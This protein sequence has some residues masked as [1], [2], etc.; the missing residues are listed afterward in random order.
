MGRKKRPHYRIV[1]MEVTAP[2]NGRALAEVGLYDP[3]KATVNINEEAVRLW[4]DRGA[5]MTPTVKS[6]MQSQ[7]VLSRWKGNEGRIREDALLKDKPKRKRKLAEAAAA[8]EAAEPAAEAGDAGT[9]ETPAVQEE[10]EAVETVEEPA[11]EAE[12]TESA[13][14]EESAE[15]TD[16]P[17]ESSET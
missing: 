12:A 17:A 4:L 3:L 11:A 14:P 10:A 9:A 7:G 8:T 6:L 5:Q 2:R 1:A 13:A 16:K 15:A